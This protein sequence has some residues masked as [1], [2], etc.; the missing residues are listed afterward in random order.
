MTKTLKNATIVH[1]P[2]D[3]TIVT[4]APLDENPERNPAIRGFSTTFEDFSSL[5]W[6]RK[7][8]DHE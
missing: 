6:M 2:L 1:A 5:H 4:F 8:N 3:S 7:S